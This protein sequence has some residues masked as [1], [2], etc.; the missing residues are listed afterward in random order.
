MKEAVFK[1]LFSSLKTRL[2][3]VLLLNT[4]IPLILLGTVSYSFI[5]SIFEKKI[6]GGIRDM[7]RQTKIGLENA[8]NNMEYAS[9]QLSSEG[10]VGE[11]LE[12]LLTSTSAFEQMQ[13][14][15][16]IMKYINV[17]NFSNP[18]LGILLYYFSRDEEVKFQSMMVDPH[19]NLQKLPLLSSV[20]GEFFYGPHRT[21]YRYGNNMVFSLAR[22]I[23]IKGY[24]QDAVY[25]YIETNFKLFEDLLNPNVYGMKATHLLLN[26]Q[27]EVYYSDD[28]RQFP[29]GSGKALSLETSGKMNLDDYYLF[30]DRSEQ[31]WSIAVA[32]VKRDF[33][34][35]FYKWLLTFGGVS[36]LC[37]FISILLALLVWRSV[38]WP[39]KQIRKEIHF[40]ATSEFSRTLKWTHIKEF[41]HVLNEFDQT[42][43]RIYRLF[44]EI[45]QKEREK[46]QLQLEKLMHQINP[47]FIHNTL[48]TIQWIARMNGQREIDRLVSIF[49]RIIHYNLAK[50]GGIVPLREEIQALEDYVTLQQIRY[51][52]LFEVR[53]HVED[54]LMNVCIPR[55]ILQPLIENAL[56]HGL[57]DQDGSIDLSI[58]EQEGY[59]I[60]QVK[61]NG[62]GMSEAEVVRLFSDERNEHRKT[63]IGIGLNYVY[64]MIKA[65]YGEESQ[66][67]IDTRIGQG[68]VITLRI[69]LQHANGG[70]KPSFEV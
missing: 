52:H 15:E 30:K 60:I 50:E 2:I 64:R 62:A 65:H 66:F 25:V 63:G 68:T 58:D 67:H 16:E 27:G 5:Q 51:D 55:F 57:G 40:M 9:L 12:R 61:D 20:K 34:S 1:S 48:N 26:E 45:Q 21:T 43:K 49:T 19:F 24:D 44:G 39:L 22:P 41:D 53:F 7:L 31:G 18:N 42:R 13:I 70:G 35:G 36:F 10:S 8:F 32:I 56:Y 4:L 6:E 38:Y 47:H 54:R 59:L 14:T 69:P 33:Y 37:L 23:K 28:Q 3:V 29:P 17:V 11:R 46:A